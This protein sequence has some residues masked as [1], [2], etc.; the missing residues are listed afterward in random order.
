M[1][2]NNNN[3]DLEEKLSS[4]ELTRTSKGINIKV[5]IYHENPDTAMEKA[6]E[7]FDKLRRIYDED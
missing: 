7:I 6:R 4:I 5:K 3:N 2:E 1:N